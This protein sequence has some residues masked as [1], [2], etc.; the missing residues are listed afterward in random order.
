[1]ITV[2]ATSVSIAILNLQRPGEPKLS[3]YLPHFSEF[4][5]NFLLVKSSFSGLE[6]DKSVHSVLAWSRD[7][8]SILWM[9]HVR[10]ELSLALR[11][12]VLTAERKVDEL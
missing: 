8:I 5:K 7:A 6:N 12:K 11:R 1:M 9:L 3:Q 10:D 2:I 4:S